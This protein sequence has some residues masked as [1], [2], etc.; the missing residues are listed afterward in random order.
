[1]VVAVVVTTQPT[2][3]RVPLLQLGHVLLLLLP[4]VDQNSEI[5]GGKERVLARLVPVRVRSFPMEAR[6]T[7]VVVVVAPPHVPVLP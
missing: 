7:C 1:V 4:H 6:S 2:L 5:V 3:L